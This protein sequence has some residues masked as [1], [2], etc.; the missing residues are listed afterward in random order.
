MVADLHHLRERRRA[1]VSGDP[2]R[3]READLLEQQELAVVADAD[4]TLVHS[5]FEQSYLARLMPGKQIENIGWIA[6]PPVRTTGF[7]TRSDLV[8]VGGYGHPPNVDAVEYFV[9]DIWPRIKARL[10]DARFLIVGSNP[11]D[12]WQEQRWDGVEVVGYVKDLDACLDRCRLSVVPLRYGAGIKG[13]IISC[14]ARGL[15]VVTTR[16]GAEGIGLEDGVN[17][18]IADDPAEFTDR[19]VAL[20]SDMALWNRLSANGMK[21]VEEKFS[22]EK[23]VQILRRALALP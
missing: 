23:G 4:C 11:P 10:G 18:L 14:M 21:L 16:I 13:K 9:A 22:T 5:D 12:T 7:E 2:V 15:P 19:V 6:P 1:E 20:Y 3:S 17:A 8:Y